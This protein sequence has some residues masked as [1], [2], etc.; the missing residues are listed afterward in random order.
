MLCEL[1]NETWYTVQ[2]MPYNYCLKTIEWK[3]KLDEAK[4]KKIEE[5]NK[6]VSRNQERQASSQKAAQRQQSILNNRKR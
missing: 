2:F 3:I 1:M 6:S 5:Y 4:N